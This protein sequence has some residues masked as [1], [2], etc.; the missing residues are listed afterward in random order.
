VQHAGRVAALQPGDL[1][2][3]DLWLRLPGRPLWRQSVLHLYVER[4][5][6]TALCTLAHVNAPLARLHESPWCCPTSVLD[7]SRGV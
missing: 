5:T 7:V 3:H 4:A 6:W 1:G 2:V